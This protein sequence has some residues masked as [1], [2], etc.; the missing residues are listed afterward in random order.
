VGCSKVG[1]VP[2]G[3]QGIVRRAMN[4]S[5]ATA[6]KIS[7]HKSSIIRFNM[8]RKWKRMVSWK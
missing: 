4:T 2:K 8:H 3:G 5:R 7:W 6:F 1:D